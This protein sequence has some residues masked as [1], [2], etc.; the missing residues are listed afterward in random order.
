H[1]HEVFETFKVFQKEVENQLGKTIKSLCSDREGEYMSQEFLDHLKDHRIITHRTPPYTPQHNESSARD[2]VKIREDRAIEPA[3]T[4]D[5]FEP[6][7]GDLPDHASA[8]GSSVVMQLGL[9]MAVQQLYDH[10]HE[11]P[12]GRIKDI[13]AGQRGLEVDRLISKRE[14]ANMIGRIGVLERDTMRL[15]G[16]LCVERERAD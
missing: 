7:R 12:I 16:M 11:I 9:D 8:D 6:T 13:E 14:M 15:R 5:S 4:N 1:K 3:V 10:M 2:T